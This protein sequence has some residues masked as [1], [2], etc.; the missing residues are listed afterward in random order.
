MTR[1]IL[2]A[3]VMLTL[4]LTMARAQDNAQ[5]PE[6]SQA[7]VAATPQERSI[8]GLLIDKEEQ[9]PVIQ[10]TVQLLK[11]AD[12]SYVAGAVSD[13]DG[14]FTLQAPENGK[15]ILKIT[16]IGYKTV[17]RNVT[18]AGDKPFAFGKINLETDAVMLKEVVANGVA[19]KVIVKEDT[20]IYNAAAYRTPEGSVIEEL[21][22]RLPGAQIDDDGKITING[23]EVKKIKVDGKEFMTGDTQ[24]ALKNLPTA[25]IDKVKA[26]DEKSDMAKL[27]GVDDGEEETILDFNIKKGMNKGML[28]NIDLS[29]GTKSRYAEQGMF[30]WMKENSRLFIFGSA[31]NTGDRGF[32][33][34][35]RGGFGNRS[36]GLQANKMLAANYNYEKKDKLKA[37]FS[38]RWNHGDTDTWTSRASENFIS[39][40]GSFSNSVSTSYDRSNSWNFTGRLEWKPDTMTTISF[41]PTFT[42]SS[43]DSRSKSTSASFNKDPYTTANP[44][45]GETASDPLDKEFMEAL[46]D[47][48]YRASV[49]SGLVADSLL[50]NRRDNNSLS[51]GTN[52]KLNLQAVASRK[53]SSRGNSV[54]VQARYSSTN[55]D[56]EAL[57]TQYVQLYRPTTEDSI[58]YKNRYNLTPG[59]NKT[60]SITGTYSERLSKY[61]FLQLR[62][63][64]Q[65]SHRTNSRSTY[66]FFNKDDYSQFENFSNVGTWAY[67]NFHTFTD[68]YAP[69]DTYYSD[70][71]S[72]YS[73]YNN[74]THEIELTWRRVTNAYNLNLGVMLQPQTQHMIYDYLNKH[75]DVARSV[76]NFT[77]TL[78]FRYKFNK[79]K[80]LRLNYRGSTSQPSMTDMLPITDDSDPLNISMGNPELKPS[81][82]QR[83]ELRYSNYVQKHMRTIMA[84]INYSNTSNS[85]SNMTTYNESTGGRTTK[86]MNIDGN[87][88]IRS[89]FM[90]NTALD[91][92]GVWNISSMT[93]V[94]YQNHASYVNLNKS[95]EATTNYTRSTSLSER[96]G[97][98][99]RN[100]WLEVEPNG[101]VTYTITRN[102]L[103]PNANLDTWQFQYGVD[104]TAT[105]PWGTSLSTGA[106]M[107]S[108]R[109]YS[110]ASMN[111]NEFIW[112]AQVS[113][114]F[115]SKKNLIVSLQ[116]ND[117]L[118][119]KSSFSRSISATQ[120]SDTYYNSIN[121]Y[122]MLHVIYR[123]NAFGGKEG[124]KAMRQGRGEGGD[125][126]GGDIPGMGDGGGRGNRGGGDFGGGRGGFGGGGR[127]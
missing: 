55:K 79:R 81:F 19:A 59:D 7:Q 82:T 38:I 95:A 42:T 92:T 31:N 108:R 44:E 120:R 71:L 100:T 65:Y 116:L 14:A 106:H 75:Y 33:T 119:Q 56:N 8:T 67:R 22:K 5:E 40:I 43:S 96:L 54:T 113:H 77:P 25:I 52:N 60:F 110:D 76:T 24:T 99:Y 114:S 15:Y 87:W 47:A 122:A 90:F 118:N 66:D 127:F 58:Y 13:L 17:T 63:M 124:R 27:T 74:Y 97:M 10:A 86:P 11:A 9:E 32:S 21:V 62:Y 26:Y 84:F 83:F 23:K 101:N 53:L 4:S 125:R 94:S 30:G 20:F 72:R 28:A 109:G 102:K 69:I 70:S 45:T 41:R 68:P 48:L 46:N 6:S 88:N 2:T 80:T 51:Y 57:S 85:V 50:I 18:I 91:T 61:S 34:G 64:Y 117:I 36:N 78:D 105:A 111:T 123:F 29:I 115:L 107:S 49:G 121:S 39:T 16:N 35:G 3:I 104:I 112:N 73:E 12:S 93:N 1:K 126:P 37:D 98:S 103:Q 89:A